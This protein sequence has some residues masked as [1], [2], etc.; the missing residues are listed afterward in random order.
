MHNDIV[1]IKREGGEDFKLSVVVST[2]KSPRILVRPLTGGR[3]DLPYIHSLNLGL[4]FRVVDRHRTWP[5]QG[6]KCPSNKLLGRNYL[7]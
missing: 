5:D 2:T 1:A 6:K 4:L 7:Q 3:Q